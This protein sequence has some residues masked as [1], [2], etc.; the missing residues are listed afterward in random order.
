MALRAPASAKIEQI[1][2]SKITGG[3]YPLL[4]S[5]ER[6]KELTARINEKDDPLINQAIVV[7]SCSCVEIFTKTLYADAV[8]A[9]RSDK[10]ILKRIFSDIEIKTDHAIDISSSTFTICDI[11]YASVKVSSSEDFLK[12]IKKLLYALS[13]AQSNF[14]FSGRDEAPETKQK[15]AGSIDRLEKQ[16]M[17]RHQLIHDVAALPHAQLQAF[18]PSPEDLRNSI[19]SC[20]ELL[21]LALEEYVV[22]DSPQDRFFEQ[23]H[24]NLHTVVDDIDV[25]LNNKLQELIKILPNRRHAEVKQYF[26]SAM[27]CLK[28][29]AVFDGSYYIID[30]SENG[31]ICYVKLAQEFLLE[32]DKTIK[33]EEIRY[34]RLSEDDLWHKCRP[35]IGHVENT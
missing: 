33:R 5:I 30:K 14:P 26:T 12:Q 13:G 31:M 11:I 10:V 6:L 19:Q 34:Q 4:D 27:R 25:Q 23:Y 2:A 32:M 21:E 7:F 9:F 1:A 18:C 17:A 16:F 8:H 20:I 15:L 22:I 24:G 35:D 28:D 29:R 3:R